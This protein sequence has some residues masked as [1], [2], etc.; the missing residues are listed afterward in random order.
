MDMHSI[1]VNPLF[2]SD[3]DLHTTA[4][5]LDGKAVP[6]PEV[7]T[8][9]D[10]RRRDIIVPDIGA[11]EFG[12]IANYYPDALNDTTATETNETITIDVLANDSDPDGDKITITAAR[13]PKHGQVVIAQSGLELSYTSTPGYAGP[14]SCIYIIS[15]IMD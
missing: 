8:D 7:R 3:T 4:A 5:Q 10:G 1:S 6:L 2:V 14:D 15:D 9:I 11:A 12:P 13:T